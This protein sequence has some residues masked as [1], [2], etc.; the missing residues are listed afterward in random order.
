[1]CTVV[2]QPTPS[3]CDSSSLNQLE[4]VSP[5][6]FNVAT[7][8][9]VSFVIKLLFMNPRGRLHFLVHR[10]Y[11]EYYYTTDALSKRY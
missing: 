10:G 1:M 2:A 5:L 3:A 9:Q 8:I 6:L 4:T 7:K 11:E